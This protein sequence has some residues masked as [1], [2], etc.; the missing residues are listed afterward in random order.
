MNNMKK[1]PHKA[2]KNKIITQNE[3][4]STAMNVAMAAVL[5]ATSIP[6][7]ASDTDDKIESSFKKS[8]IYIKPI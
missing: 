5:L 8:Y 6:L 2:S 7:F 4:H 3:M 1:T